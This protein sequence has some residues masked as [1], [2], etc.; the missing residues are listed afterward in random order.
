MK[1]KRRD[2]ALLKTP[3][4]RL[5]VILAILRI[6]G[7]GGRQLLTRA[8]AHTHTHIYIYIYKQR[9]RERDTHTHTKREREREKTQSYY[10]SI[11]SKYFNNVEQRR[12]FN[13][14]T[15]SDK[16]INFGVLKSGIR[17][18]IRPYYTY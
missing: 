1:M 6:G 4:N 5:D 14:S 7:F 17:V 15:F 2:T 13:L 18:N 8:H 10:Y 16:T 12:R 3:M 11:S 9:E